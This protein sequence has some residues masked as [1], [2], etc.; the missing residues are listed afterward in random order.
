MTTKL[1]ESHRILAIDALRGFDMFWIIG[2]AS[3]LKN[4]VPLLS[5][6]IHHFIL[7]QLSH[8]QWHGF[9]FYDLIMPLF[10]FIVGCSMAF[11]LNQRVN[12]GNGIKLYKH[13]LKRFSIHLYLAWSSKVIC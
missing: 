10:M 5:P 1:H 13:V 2:G 4:L 7:N 8:S 3:I 9:T 6:N 11:S 12:Q